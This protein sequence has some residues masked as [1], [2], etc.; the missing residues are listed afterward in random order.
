MI[1]SDKAYDLLYALIMSN[2]RSTAIPVEVLQALYGIDKAYDLLYAMDTSANKGDGRDLRVGL[3]NARIALNDH[4]KV[5]L[6]DF[7][8]YSF[9]QFQKNMERIDDDE[10]HH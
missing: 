1:M 5:T 10:K 9:E 6:E 7:L 2:K 3:L 4:F 8:I